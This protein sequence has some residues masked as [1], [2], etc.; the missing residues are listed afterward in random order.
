MIDNRQDD[1]AI[2]G[3]SCIYPGAPD[4]KSFWQNIISKV[5][6]VSDAPESW[7]ADLFFDPNSEANDRIYCKKGGFIDEFVEFNPLE[8]NI[9][10]GA[11][12]G[13]DPEPFMALRL[14]QE[15]IADAGY[16]ER[17]FDRERTGVI[18]GKGN[19]IDRGKF[20]CAQH[21]I[22][23]DQVLRII[24]H[25]NPDISQASLQRIKKELKASL[26]PYNTDNCPW[27]VSN[28]VS[29]GIANRLDLKG[30]NFTVDAACAS[31]V[32]ALNMGMR[33]LLNHT[34][35]MVLI[36]GSQLSTTPAVFQ[37]FCQL[38]ALSRSG[39]IRPFDKD[40]DGTL[41]AEGIGMVVIKRL[42]DARRD[43]DRI[44]ALIKSIGIASDGRGASI[45][46]PRVE[47][48][49]LA[50]NRAY[51]ES[52][53]APDSIDMIE[54]HGTGTT[55]GDVIEIQS[56]T[57]MFGA[58]K[59]PVPNCAI[60]SVK[61]MIA[62]T[63][64]AAGMAGLIKTALALYHKVLP[65][66]LVD[67]PN[68]D[69]G[70]SKTPFYLNTEPRPW[71]NGK[72]NP[73]RAGLN[74]FGFGGINTHTILE[75]Y[76]DGDIEKRPS[77][78]LYQWDSELIIIQGASHEEMM[79]MGKNVLGY[80][81]ANQD[82]Y[83]K[84]LAF[85]MNCPLDDANTHRLAIV[86]TSVQDLE[87]KL[88]FALKRME[89][90]QCR[91][92][93]DR[94]GIFF[95][96]KP[97]RR[98]GKMAFLFPG[99]G[100]QYV[101][102]LSDLCIHFP[103]IRSSFDLADRIFFK[104]GKEPL[105]SQVLFP[106]SDIP[107]KVQAELNSEFWK[108]EYAKFSVFAANYGL[109]KLLG[110]L[111]IRPQVVVGHSTGEDVALLASKV[112]REQDEEQL[113]ENG[114]DIVA[115]NESIK[116]QIPSAKLVA[117]GAVDTSEI[118]EVIAR[119][120][121]K[122]FV[123]MDNCPN[124]MILSGSEAVVGDACNQLK[125]KGA[126]LNFLPFGRAYHTPLYK[127]VCTHFNRYVEQL[128]IQPPRIPIYSCSTARPF[129]QDLEGIRRLMVKQWA[130]PVRFRETIKAMY[131]DGVR[132]F[133]EVGPNGN[134]TSFVQDTLG[135][136]SYVAVAANVHARSGTSQLN[137]MIG[138]L[139]AHGVDMKLEYLYARREPKRIDVVKSI[140]NSDE[141]SHGSNE[142]KKK[143]FM[144]LDMG[145]KSISLDGM[146]KKFILNLNAGEGKQV[147]SNETKASDDA[148]EKDT[149]PGTNSQILE[150]KNKEQEHQEGLIFDK[151]YIK[152]DHSLKESSPVTT[153][154]K[155]SSEAYKN[156]SSE[157]KEPLRFNDKVIKEYLGSMEQFLEL[158]EE[159]MRSYLKTKMVKV[160]KKNKDRTK[161]TS[162]ISKK[163]N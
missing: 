162:F 54:A 74:S 55:V 66:T 85:S 41:L 106:I 161:T 148:V 50:I 63:I 68:P 101:N 2:I 102:M 25:I 8:F 134:L 130:L 65:P 31:S 43:G 86:A 93:K 123:A 34:C 60:G 6:A 19:S 147:V 33:E 146:N 38:G 98:E 121:G 140:K 113:F 110:K 29:G 89:D 124:Q 141:K 23:V 100:S 69:L 71:I 37:I 47:G 5:D 46:A 57:Q 1:I 127:P 59:G 119:Y 138:L 72:Q 18:I 91:Q 135:R 48:E 81:V 16:I 26:P 52:G 94:S 136:N 137:Q 80:I 108:L 14:A 67:E 155:R 157:P 120:D 133:V 12:E 75:E 103:E 40:A 154:L 70:L 53:I 20:T 88:R 76:L 126:I 24:K 132:I 30:P 21:V 107:S 122:I 131:D 142:K 58:R 27:L 96:Q 105:P 153:I 45:L 51:E 42:E 128:P 73:R 90:K 56:L 160:K 4:L 95:F 114:L 97:L 118:K 151:N 82:F 115:I 158:Q 15:A 83:L 17:S 87:K 159:V 125:K 32:I 163:T 7:R 143:G 77:N 152:S 92:V 79:Q 13:A 129:P 109:N 150:R 117:I 111:D 39:R 3:M 61:S 44:Y 22:V 10:P 36:G 11:V 28:L 144:K 149:I 139:A 62:H 84:D 35:D 9:M 112:I 49:F 99:E 64:P 156:I 145:V 78:L 104:K 116:S